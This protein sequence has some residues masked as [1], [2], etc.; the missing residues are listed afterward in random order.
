MTNKPQRGSSWI[1]TPDRY[2]NARC[3]L[4]NI[5]NEDDVECFKWCV[6]Y[7]QSK[8][9]KHCDRVSV[10]KKIE[11][12]Y[13]YSNVN[14]PATFDDIAT[15]EN[16]NISVFVYGIDEENNIRTEKTGN[17]DYIQNDII[18]LLRVENDETSHYIYIKHVERLFNLHHQG[19]DKDK[20]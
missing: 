6:K 16:N 20:K 13:D 15:F 7:H 11:D 12:K 2:N 14:C 10:L 3:G 4:I 1:P 19:C 17:I 9:E 5:R 8:K 18:Y